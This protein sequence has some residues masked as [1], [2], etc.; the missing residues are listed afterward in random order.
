VI[1]LNQDVINPLGKTK[2][3]LTQLWQP[4]ENSWLNKF[5]PN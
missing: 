4:V 3:D 2:A 1:T 5:F